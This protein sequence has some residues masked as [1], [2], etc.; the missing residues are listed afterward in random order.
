MTKKTVTATSHSNLA[1][2]KYWGKLDIS[3]NIPTNASISVLLPKLVT[4]TEIAYNCEAYDIFML[5]NVNKTINDKM[6]T[7]IKHFKNI[8][9][10]DRNI[11][12]KSNN[13]FPHSCGMASSASGFS[14]LVKALNNFYETNIPLDE[15]CNLARYGSGS[16][17]R[18]MHDGIVKWDKDGVEYIGRWDELRAFIIVINDSVKKIGSTE[19]MI[20]TVKTS[21]LF[22]YRLQHIDKKIQQALDYIKT[23]DFVNLGDLV[24]RE[25]NEIHAIFLDTFPPI[26]Y[27]NNESMNVINHVLELNKNEFKAFYTFDAGSNPTIFV[28]E[29]NYNEVYEYFKT[30]DY[31]IIE[32]K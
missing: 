20:R 8:A 12:I 22:Q 23:K 10:D 16:A 24:M 28:L 3:N 29:K 15:L 2:I 31:K 18:S 5:D 13:N 27:L 4:E 19:G 9:N 1:L 26:L 30:K 21:K 32:G 6:K 25:S 11:T 7:L 17:A 14:A